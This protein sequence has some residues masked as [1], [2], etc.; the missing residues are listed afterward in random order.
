[1]KTSGKEKEFKTGSKRD[2]PTG[3]PRMELLPMDLLMRLSK[4][5]GLG[6]EKYGDN[7]WRKGQPKKHV[8]GSLLRHLTK[9]QMGMTDEDHLSA[10]IWNALALMNVDEYYADNEYL[11]NLND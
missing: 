3:K 11:N 2:D 6:A 8:M 5:Y 7:N 1:M 4:W 10:V 9:Y